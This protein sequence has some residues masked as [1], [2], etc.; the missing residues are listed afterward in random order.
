MPRTEYEY[1]RILIPVS[2]QQTLRE[3]GYSP[4][5]SSNVSAI[6]R[7]NSTLYIR[8]HNG[9]VYQYPNQGSKYGD[10]L[11]APSKGKWVWDNLRRKNVSYSKVGNIPLDGDRDL[12]DEELFKEISKRKILVQSVLQVAAQEAAVSPLQ[13]IIATSNADLTKGLLVGLIVGAL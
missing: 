4:V 9:S 1:E 7:V 5:F 8:F 11:T 6:S 3:L 13:T 10:L 2:D 12:T